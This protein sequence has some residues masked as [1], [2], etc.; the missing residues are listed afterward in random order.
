M[1][2]GIHVSAALL[3]IA[4]VGCVGRM[5]PSAAERE[6]QTVQLTVLNNRFEDA[7]IHAVWKGGAKRRVGVVTG[8]TSQTFTFEWVSEVVRFEVDFVAADDYTVE[9]ID[10]AVGDHLD[11]VILNKG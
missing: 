5:A 7:T 4:V 11:L 6:P 1:R 2:K 8:G 10:V 9:P 3:C